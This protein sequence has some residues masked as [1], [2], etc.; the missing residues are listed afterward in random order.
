MAYVGGRG[1]RISITQLNGNGDT[2]TVEASTA[3]NITIIQG[4]GS[5]DTATIRR[6]HLHHPRQWEWRYGHG[7]DV[8]VTNGNITISQSDVAG[9]AI[10][11]TANVI[12][13]THRDHKTPSASLMSTVM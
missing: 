8:T 2:A 9:N 10:G 3:G 1:R 12:G 6:H 7:L 11:D 5:G 13:V 4:S